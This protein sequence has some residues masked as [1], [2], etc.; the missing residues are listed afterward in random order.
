MNEKAHKLYRDAWSIADGGDTPGALNKIEDALSIDSESSVLWVTKAQFLA[1]L[2]RVE[3]AI[4]AAN[5]SVAKGPRNVHAWVL[6]GG[7]SADQGNHAAAVSHFENALRLDD[8]FGTHTLMAKS[9]MSIDPKRAATHAQK[10]LDINPEWSDAKELLDAA[11]R[12][13]GK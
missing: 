3:E 12:V 2:G 11:Q 1:D 8:D 7:L 13:Q 10:A 9:L 4:A 5:T 6:L